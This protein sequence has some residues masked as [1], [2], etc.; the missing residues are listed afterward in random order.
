MSE[1]RGNVELERG[2]GSIGGNDVT[3]D[4]GGA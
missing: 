2:V 1:G 4:I 3:V